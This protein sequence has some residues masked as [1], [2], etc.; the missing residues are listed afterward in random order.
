VS[1]HLMETPKLNGLITHFPVPGSNE[2]EKVR[3]VEQ[4][5]EEKEA[6]IATSRPSVRVSNLRLP[7]VFEHQ[8]QV[9]IKPKPE[10]EPRP[11]GRVYINKTQY[12]EGIEPEVWE[13]QIGGYQVLHKWLTDRK[14]RKLTFDDLF[15]WQKIVVALKETMRLMGEIDGLILSWPIE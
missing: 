15:H 2:V 4:V 6:P 8:T 9:E 1:L 12:F 7:L 3:Y 5:T 11:T 13:F 10:P 14:G